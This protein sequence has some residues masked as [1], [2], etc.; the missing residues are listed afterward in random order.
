MKPDP[1]CGAISIV[2]GD[3]DIRV[4]VHPDNPSIGWDG[5]NQHKLSASEEDE[6]RAKLG[7]R[8]SDEEEEDYFHGPPRWSPVH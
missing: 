3:E 6:A 7:G 8:I 1:D 2:R 4:E 5:D